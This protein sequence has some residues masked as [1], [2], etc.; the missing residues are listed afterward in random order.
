MKT[1]G[2]DSIGSNLGSISYWCSI[3]L[4]KFFNFSGPVSS[5]KKCLKIV[6]TS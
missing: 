6:S 2:S 1:L 3:S 5:Y 4:G